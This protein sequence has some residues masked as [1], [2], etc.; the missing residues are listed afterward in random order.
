MSELEVFH[1]DIENALQILDF[2]GNLVGNP[3]VLESE[4]ITSLVDGRA[5]LIPAEGG[6]LV[7]YRKSLKENYH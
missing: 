2:S 7:L 3:S 1:A 5:I 6:N 4:P